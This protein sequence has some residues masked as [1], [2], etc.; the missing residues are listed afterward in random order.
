MGAPL[1]L[2]IVGAIRRTPGSEERWFAF[3]WAATGICLIYLPVV[4]QI[5]LLSGWQFPLAVLAAHA[6]HERLRPA[7]GRRLS[8]QLAFA[9]LVLLVSSTNLYLFAWRFVDLRRHSSPYYL[10]H[11]QI[12]VLDWLA[13]SAG[14][15]DVVLAQPELGQFVPN[16]GGSRAYLAHWAMTNRFFERRANVAT[17]FQPAASD[18]WRQ[19][20]LSVEKV[21]LVV[22]TDWPAAPEATFDPAGSPRFELVF[23]RP[24]AQVYRFH[25]IAASQVAQWPAAR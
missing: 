20:L 19:R 22:R 25:S 10:H 13:H 1:L 14:T 18:D 17:F 16:Y 7:L 5:K 23:A 11:D 9:V 21:T 15:S 24:H 2:A 6:W 12:D 4:Y 8:P 3:T